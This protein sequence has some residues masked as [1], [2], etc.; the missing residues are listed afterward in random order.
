MNKLIIA[1][2]FLVVVTFLNILAVNTAFSHTTALSEKAYKPSV[3]SFSEQDIRERLDNI[4]SVIDINYTSEVGR[5]IKE[6]TVSYRKAGEQILGRVDL[7]FP[8]FEKEIH[9][10]NLPDELKYVAVV[11][12]NLKPSATS[13]LGAAGLWQFMSSTGKMKGLKI[14]HAVDERRDP[15]KSTK[16]ALEYLNDLY[17]EFDDWTLAMAA[18]NCGPGNVRKAIRR[19]GSYNYW[20]IRRFLPRETQNYVPRIIAAMYLMQY[21]HYHNLTPRIVDND[22]KYTISIADG[23]KH[24][25]YQLAKDLDLPYRTLKDLNPQFRSSYIPKNDGSYALVIPR[26]KYEDYLKIYDQQAYNDLI[27]QRR[28]RRLSRLAEI[29]KMMEKDKVE[30]LTDIETLEPKKLVADVSMQAPRQ[31]NSL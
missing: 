5:R 9:E 25:F 8:L 10:R 3:P 24:N 22:I 29:Q 15:V 14:N 7:F 20:D 16:A 2:R 12:S 23:K 27:E 18:Y 28:Q 19:G 13:N 1:T 11:E 4:S 26:T 21:Y 31:T 6:Y 17:C 30:P